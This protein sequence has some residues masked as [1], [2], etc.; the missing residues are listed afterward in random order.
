[1]STSA[2]RVVV[3]GTYSTGKTT[4]ATALSK[5]TGIP[6]VRALS[7]REIL[8]TLYPG[9]SFQH[10]SAEELLALGLRRLDERLRAETELRT[11]GGSF[12]SDGSVLN[13]WAYAAVRARIGL[14]P[15]APIVQQVVRGTLAVPALPFLRRYA[16][17]YGVMARLHTRESYTDVVHLPIEFAMRP[18]GHRPVSERYRRMSDRDL[19]HEFEELDLPVHVVCGT[20]EHRVE[21][22]IDALGL[23]RVCPTADA[24]ESARSEIAASREDVARRI[25]EQDPGL[26]L[27]EKTA[28]VFR[29]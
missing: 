22:A 8:T 19:L 5:A 18:D 16:R 2:R 23:P 21:K 29:F 3:S 12:I 15:G 20:V 6:L 27:R 7:A 13:E 4:T 14:N 1:M 11:T 28:L 26:S 17:A 10:M 9:R 25:L 24:V